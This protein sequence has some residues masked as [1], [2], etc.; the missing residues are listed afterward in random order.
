MHIISQ[1]YIGVCCLGS[2]DVSDSSLSL[3]LNAFI[4]NMKSNKIDKEQ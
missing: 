3:V 1:M 4:E 2:S